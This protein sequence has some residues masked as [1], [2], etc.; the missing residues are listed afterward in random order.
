MFYTTFVSASKKH[1][2]WIKD[3]IEKILKIEGSITK[4]KNQS[5]Y[6]LRYAKK[7]SLKI[8]KKMYYS[9]TVVCLGRK[10]LKIE[11]VLATVGEK[12]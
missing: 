4:A 12:L 5:T 2:Y 9:K 11:R 1:I 7:N 3:E 10:R 8:L 6:H